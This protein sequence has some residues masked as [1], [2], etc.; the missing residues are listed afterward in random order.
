MGSTNIGAQ[1]R[2]A[3]IEKRMTQVALAKKIGKSSQL[4]CDIEAGRK[5][6]SV[7]TLGAVVRVLGL[8]KAMDKFF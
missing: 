8:E 7:E 5:H 3:R 1:L 6:P 2:Q 4:I